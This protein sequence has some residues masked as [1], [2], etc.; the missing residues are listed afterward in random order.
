MKYEITQD[1]LNSF[2]LSA[3]DRSVV[4]LFALSQKVLVVDDVL[5]DMRAGATEG[6]SGDLPEKI[7][8][9][10]NLDFMEAMRGEVRRYARRL[11]R[12]TRIQPDLKCSL[13]PRR[14]FDERR[15]LLQHVKSHHVASKKYCPSGYKQ[16]HVA[17][18]VF[19]NDRIRMGGGS[20]RPDT[21]YLL[22]SAEFMERETQSIPGRW[23]EL[24]KMVSLVLGADGPH[25]RANIDMQGED[26]LRRVGNTLYT[27]DFAQRIY[28][29]S[30]TQEAVV[31]RV[32]AYF[33]AVAQE[34]GE[35]ASLLPRN[36]AT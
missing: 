6:S 7:R 16:L 28:S 3:T 20:P 2:I 12:K 9:T 23:T 1:A 13:C 34:R 10:P 35:V 36:A 29:T 17:Q 15:R 32:S 31:E 18:A 27:E 5:L 21:N 33:C 30:L 22:R 8:D 19:D 11:S 4:V 25:F 26:T 14:T 24:D